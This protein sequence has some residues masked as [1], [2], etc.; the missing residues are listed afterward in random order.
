MRVLAMRRSCERRMSGDEAGEPVVDEMF[1]PADLHA[2]LSECDY[3]VLT[4]PLTSESRGLIGEA[5]IA[6][7]KANAV[8][9]N[10]SR[11]SVIDQDALV[12]A[13]REGRIAGAALDVTTPEPLPSDHELWGVENVM[14]TPH[15]SGGTPR[16]MERAIDL[17]CENLRRYARGDALR[18]VVDPS[19]GY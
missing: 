14:V 17:F 18:N 16:Y 6:A 19:R 7:M 4:L 8:I 1:P 10:I 5:E 3:V 11:G 9:V 15:I 13:L 2:L 12:R